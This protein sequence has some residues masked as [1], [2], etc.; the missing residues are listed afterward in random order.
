MKSGNLKMKFMAACCCG[1]NSGFVNGV[2]HAQGM[3][4]TWMGD[5][6]RQ[7]HKKWGTNQQCADVNV[8]PGTAHERVGSR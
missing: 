7:S 2:K 6:G 1:Y 4:S 3:V 5:C 8:C